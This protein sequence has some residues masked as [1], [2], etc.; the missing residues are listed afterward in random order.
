M[1]YIYPYN[2]YKTARTKFSLFMRSALYLLTYPSYICYICTGDTYATDFTENEVIEWII[3][4]YCNW[5][6]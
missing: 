3:N 4:D 5:I 6:E 1:L 2:V